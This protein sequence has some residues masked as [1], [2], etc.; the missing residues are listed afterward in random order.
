MGKDLHY[1][2]V[3]VGAGN[4]GL[5]AAAYL[6]THGKKVLVLEKHNL[7]GGCATSFVRGRF[8][9]ESTLH[10]MCQVGEGKDKGAIRKLIDDEY[11]MR[12]K[13]VGFT[14]AYCSV[15]KEKGKA[16]DV[17]M[18]TG[19]KEFT[20]EM[21]RVVPGSRKSVETFFEMG[22][23]LMDGVDWL[24]SYHNE[25]GG[26]A[27]IKMLFKWKDLMKLV[28]IDTDTML[29]KL[30][31]PDKAREILESYWDYIATPSDSMSFGVYCFMTTSYVMRKPYI[32]H[33]RSH[34]ISL[35]FDE[36]IR[37]NGG[38]IWYLAPVKLIDVK[39]NICRG[40]ELM[41]GTY[42]SADYVICN[43]HPDTA[44]RKL[45]DPKEVPVRDRK[46]MNARTL[47]Q[48]CLSIFMALDKS[49]KELGIKGYDT[50]VRT[51]GDNRKQYENIKELRSHENCVTIL[52]EVIP[53][54]SPKGTCLVQFTKF[55][56][57]NIDTMKD[58]RIEDYFKVKEE[59]AKEA[60]KEFEEYYKVNIHD[61]IEEIV[62][63]TPAT[64]ARYIG[65]PFGGTYGYIPQNW[66]GMF[67]RVQSGHKLDHTIK[68][69]R[70]CGGHGTQ[71]DGYSQS[72]LSG[73]EQ[74][75]YALLDMEKGE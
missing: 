50:F 23:M 27:K 75:R 56:A 61:H 51:T 17:V 65:S 37:K 48:A 33:D 60:I 5:S 18:P 70:F 40:V 34:E 36:C 38:D 13:W 58:V 1:D 9:F 21:E 8:E 10:E 6:A 46:S 28:P 32:C 22:K 24:A 63:A 57:G 35:A 49:A 16:F 67:A 45:I 29:K 30:E 31:M 66:D 43:T 68:R 4:G 42:I 54:C 20:D 53:D 73:K 25:P 19:I 74:A 59:L 3:V 15:S 12:V 69:L 44:F 7:P 47:G 39:N 2:V 41:D 52:N 72:Y 14:E 71:M 64:W 11:K 26:L 62:I 55:F